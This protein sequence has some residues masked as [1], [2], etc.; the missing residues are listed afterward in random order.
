MRRF[1]T[2]LLATAA[3][4]P[5]AAAVNPPAGAVEPVTSTADE[6][7][8]YAMMSSHLSASDRQNRYIY[9]DGS[10]LATAQY[11][12]GLDGLSDVTD[13][14]WRLE[15]AG[16]GTVR[17]IHYD[18]LGVF[19]PAG[20]EETANTQLL[21]Q[22]DGSAWQLMT[23]ASTG[24]SDCAELQYVLDWAGRSGEHAYLN[25][26]DGSVTGNE[27]GVTVYNAGAHQA[28][29]WFFVPLEIEGG[30]EPDPDPGVDPEPPT[31]DSGY[32]VDDPFET[33][34]RLGRMSPSSPVYMMPAGSSGSAYI[35]SAVTS[36]D[37]V[38]YPLGYM[39]ASAPSKSFV[40]VS[41]QT[42]L[43]M[44]DAAF[45]LVLTTNGDPSSL[46]VTAW[47]DWNRDGAYEAAGQEPVIDASSRTVTQTLVVPADAALG[48]TRVR[49]RIEQSAPSG[50]DA[51]MSQGRT[52]DFVIYVL[53]GEER[54]DCY[55]SVSSSDTRYGTAYV[56]TAPNADGRYDKGTE[57]TVV[58][59]A[60][61]TSDKE[62]TF[63]GW[64]L[65]GET[66]STDTAYTFVVSESVHL[67]AMFSVPGPV[68]PEVSTEDDPVWYQIMNA[69]TDANRRDRYMAYDT[70]IDDTYTT[71][72]RAE[73]PA[74][75]TDKFLWRLEDA[76]DGMV[77]IVNKGS[78]LMIEGVNEL[79]SSPLDCGAEGSRFM[80]A[81]SGADNGSWSIMYEGISDR[82]LNAQDGTWRIVLYN[83]GIGTGSG[84]YFT[85]VEVT[86]PD[87][88]PGTGIESTDD[89]ASVAARLDDGELSLS[90][91]PAPCT[92][93]V[94]NLSGQLIASFAAAD[95][96]MTARLGSMER[97][98]L[99]VVETSGGRVAV[100]CIDV[101]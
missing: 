63:D 6:P 3:A 99:V 54:D 12:Q 100:K 11:A 34:V 26:M 2:M 19:V 73:K 60:D 9:Y 83:A 67:T 66:V 5:M 53:E 36:G 15:D 57:V 61:R 76:G 93:R 4:L 62:V 1:A 43:V 96:G 70:D 22:A 78:G 81:N 74:D 10:R 91:L 75:T 79:E 25:A 27:Y 95:A 17:L 24:Q 58:A 18:G 7:Q 90:G 87:P 35:T 20:A 86:E 16:D 50:A 30:T 51:S 32:I 82:L 85:E 52:Y 44:R 40:V 59:V 39:A 71:A 89:N 77:Y 46:S 92:V 88:G 13:Y 41:R 42:S 65:G 84:W 38:D 69:H 101:D 47:T 80:I 45:D 8:W 29:G 94:Y 68:A 55:V 98:A 33:M 28:S 64:R 21:M 56:E 48:K 97:F 49:V 23:S 31:S 37:A 14:A 72:L